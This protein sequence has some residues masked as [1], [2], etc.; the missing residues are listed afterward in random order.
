MCVIKRDYF[1]VGRTELNGFWL[2]GRI[3]IVGHAAIV[4]SGWLI[5][6]DFGRKWD[7]RRLFGG[8]RILVLLPSLHMRSYAI[9]RIPKEYGKVHGLVYITH[10]KDKRAD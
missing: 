7:V 1:L 9:S 6:G 10:S 2:R 8:A 3:V 4:V 5:V